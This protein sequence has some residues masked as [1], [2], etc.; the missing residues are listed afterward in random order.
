MKKN[1]AGIT[2]TMTVAPN[3]ATFIHAEDTTSNLETPIQENLEVSQ[4]ISVQD[5]LKKAIKAEQDQQG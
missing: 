2:A 5:A 3:A 1:I 4:N